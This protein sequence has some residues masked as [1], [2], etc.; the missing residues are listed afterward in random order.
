MSVE[1]TLPSPPRRVGSDA[2]PLGTDRLQRQLGRYGLA[3]ALAAR[4]HQL[5]DMRGTGTAIS[6]VGAMEQ[7]MTDICGGR[8][9][10]WYPE[11]PPRRPRPARRPERRAKAA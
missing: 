8:V 7:A 1:R 5:V 3:A 9:R 11:G 6:D 4:A 10:A 2:R